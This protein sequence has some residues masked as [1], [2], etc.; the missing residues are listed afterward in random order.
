MR[1]SEF[2]KEIIE[3]AQ[4]FAREKMKSLRSSHGW[5]HVHRVILLAMK[6]ARVE[7]ADSFIVTTAAILHDIARDREDRSGGK[8]C[9]AGHGAVIADKFLKQQGLDSDRRAHIAHCIESHRYRNSIVPETIEARVLFDADKL[10]SIGAI[11]IGRAF[12][13]SGEV[14]ARLHNPDIDVRST[15]AYSE[16]DTAFR[17]YAVKLQYVKK[18]M[19]TGEGRR[20]AAGRHE[21]MKLFFSRIQAEA[22]GRK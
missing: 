12:L 7:K 5:D 6:I 14:G 21:F 13:F 10:D 8:I 1:Y 9:H 15:H 16:E 2:E 4:S 18:S 3:N 17:E 22:K 20:I 11:G 19:L